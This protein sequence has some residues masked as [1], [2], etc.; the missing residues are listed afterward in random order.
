MAYIYVM[1][2]ANG[3]M[4]IGFSIDPLRRLSQIK[5]AGSVLALWVHDNVREV[6]AFAHQSLAPYRR[7]GEW[8]AVDCHAA[9]AAVTK[10]IKECSP[11]TQQRPEPPIPPAPEIPDEDRHRLGYLRPISSATIEQQQMWLLAAGVSELDI[12]ADEPHEIRLLSASL[13]DCREGDIYCAWSP[14]V[15]GDRASV[16][17]EAVARRGAKLV[18]AE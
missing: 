8:F 10:A 12:F 3:H 18:F 2:R 14:D 15:F 5:G 11:K 7:D 6:E 9:F 17:A 4:K 13:K 16:V 1:T